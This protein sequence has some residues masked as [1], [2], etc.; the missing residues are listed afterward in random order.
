MSA[1][2]IGLAHAVHHFTQN[3]GIRQLVGTARAMQHGIIL[4]ERL[5]LRGIELLE[6]IRHNSRSLV[7][8]CAVD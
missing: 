7:D 1:K 5:D 3:L 4:F 2:R 8:G 6:V